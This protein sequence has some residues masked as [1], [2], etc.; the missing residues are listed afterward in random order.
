MISRKMSVKTALKLFI[1]IFVL[2]SSLSCT[3]KQDI[4]IDRS[5]KGSCTVSVDLNSFFTEYLKDLSDAAGSPEEEF[6]VFDRQMIEESF[7]KNSNAELADVRIKGS[8]SI[9][10]DIKFNNPGDIL[11]E[12]SLNPVISYTRKGSS[13][14]VSFNLNTEN[15]KALSRMTGLA[16]NPVLAALTPQPENPYTN[17]EYLDMV[18]FVFSDYEGGDIAAVTMAKSMVEINIETEGRVVSAG[19]GTFS[20][21]RAVFRI[22]LLKFLTLSEP[23]VFSVEYR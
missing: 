6:T 2:F 9:E 8:G 3:V 15:Y 19:N 1:V 7:S 20:G 12:N 5:G 10:L 16:D 14:I 18:D 22:P 4:N 11:R 23:V 17:D 21:S 13:S